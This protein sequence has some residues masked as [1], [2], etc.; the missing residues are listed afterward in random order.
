MNL[1]VLKFINGVHMPVGV[2]LV[3]LTHV[4]LYQVTLYHHSRYFQ[5]FYERGQRNSYLERKTKMWE[6]NF[7]SL[8][9]ILEYLDS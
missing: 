5:F 8:T 3:I 7:C 1:Y 6:N 4:I 2:H 9:Y